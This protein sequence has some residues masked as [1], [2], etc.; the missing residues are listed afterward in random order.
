[1]EHNDYTIPALV[2]GQPLPLLQTVGR[3]TATFAGDFSVQSA[4]STG[5]YLTLLQGKYLYPN[6]YDD[7]LLSPKPLDFAH[8]SRLG[9]E[10]G[11]PRRL[12]QRAVQHPSGD[13]GA[14]E[15]RR[16][17]ALEPGGQRIVI[18]HQH[19]AFACGQILV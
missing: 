6:G 11:F 3:L 1:M 17:L 8:H 13:L 7:L 12:S 9:L 18:G 19:A 15:G 5:Y 10:N 2:V 4:G 14:V 16:A